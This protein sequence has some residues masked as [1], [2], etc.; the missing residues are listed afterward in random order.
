MTSAEW[1]SVCEAAWFRG[2]RVTLVIQRFRFRFQSPIFCNCESKSPT[3]TTDAPRTALTSCFLLNA[4][5]N[6]A[7]HLLYTDVPR[8]YSGNQSE[9][10]KAEEKGA[11]KPIPQVY[12][13][14]QLRVLGGCML[15]VRK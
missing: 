7:E 15:Y 9:K 14:L 5:D 6:F 3:A 13:K 2:L 11:L 1:K 12:M 8:L 4:T 10:N